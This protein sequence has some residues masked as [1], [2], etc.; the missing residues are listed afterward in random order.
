MLMVFSCDEP[1]T[2]VVNIIHPDGSVTR[3]IEMRNKKNN[4][5]KE[6]L[7]VPFDS[8]WAIKDTILIGEKNDTTWIKTAEKLF[9]SAEEINMAYKSDKTGNRNSE[10]S[11]SFSRKF[12]WFN[13]T[14]RFSERF[15][16]AFLYGDPL[17]KYFTKEE[18]DLIYMP[19][20]M[21]DELKNGPDSIRYRVI[22]D[23]I[24]QKG[25]KW[26]FGS[27]AIEW[28]EEFTRLCNDRLPDSLSKDILKQKQFL[29]A[30]ALVNYSDSVA[31]VSMIGLDNYMKFRTEADSSVS[32]VEK[33]FDKSLSFK[34]YSMKFIMPGKLIGTNGYIS[35]TGDI[36]WE[37]RGELFLTN[38]YEVWAESKTTNIWTWVITGLFILFVGAGL[39]TKTLRK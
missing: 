11:A 8:T 16:K 6:D 23:T 3:R 29:G 34:N 38:D 33:R 9:R 24:D 32:I 35:K 20:S 13:T 10:R 5:K 31:V 36:M 25:Q 4:F 21:M 2:T 18:T 14:Y 19:E 30:E 28:I 27:A 39:L 37:I 15:G 7:Q 22:S 17:E 12:R 1:E 26:V